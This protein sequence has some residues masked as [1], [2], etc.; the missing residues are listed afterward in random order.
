VFCIH[1]HR[2]IKSVTRQPSKLLPA[3][4]VILKK[5]DNI[6]SPRSVPRRSRR[7]AGVGVEF[8]ASDLDR[9]TT[10]KIMK[11]VG[12]IADNVG[13]DQR[14]QEE[15]ADLFKTSLS[16]T[17]VKALAALFGWQLPDHL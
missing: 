2:L 14:A 1:Y 3:P 12:I 13:I 7:V 5:K 17:H 10:K 4:L 16:N 6:L 9:R 15:Y 11:A 8:N